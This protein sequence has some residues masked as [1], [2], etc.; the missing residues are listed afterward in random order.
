MAD[1]KP[2][3]SL[4]FTATATTSLHCLPPLPSQAFHCRRHE[5][6]TIAAAS[7]HRCPSMEIAANLFSPYTSNFSCPTSLLQVHVLKFLFFKFKCRSEFFFSNPSQ[8]TSKSA[9]AWK[10]HSI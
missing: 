10:V 8:G 2:S 3:P 7:S 5:P 4:G 6:P 9:L 1:K